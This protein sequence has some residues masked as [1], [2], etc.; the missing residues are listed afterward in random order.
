M[1]E[2]DRKACFYG[3]FAGFLDAAL[4]LDAHCYYVL[5]SSVAQ[6]CGQIRIGPERIT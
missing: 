2:G 1:K 4:A 3:A 6:A 5:N